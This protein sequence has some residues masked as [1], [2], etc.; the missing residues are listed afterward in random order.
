[1]AHFN[2]LVGDVIALDCVRVFLIC[3][4]MGLVKFILFNKQ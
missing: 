1:M 2:L 3:L 4:L